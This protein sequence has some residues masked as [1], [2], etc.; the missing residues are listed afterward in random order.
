MDELLER[1]E[2][3]VLTLTIAREAQRNSLSS[4]LV[5]GMIEALRRALVSPDV[6][7]VVLTGAGS[8]AF[9]AGG[10]LGGGAGGDGFLSAH[11]GRRRYAALLQ[12]IADFEKPTI[13][14]VN[15]LALAGG[16]GLVCACDLAVAADDATCAAVSKRNGTDPNPLFA[17]LCTWPHPEIRSSS[18]P[19]HREPVKLRSSNTY[20]S[21]CLNNW[22]SP[23]PVQPVHHEPEKQTGLNTISH[24]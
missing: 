12:T 3:G 8:K 24:P 23:F 22:H 10:D 9:C 18:L 13:A 6:R 11:E 2:G 4:T 20:S 14:R 21:K 16:L 15:G 17:F 1:C 7:V 5:E 19:P